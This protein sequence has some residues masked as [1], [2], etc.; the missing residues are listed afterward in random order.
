MIRL[1]SAAMK[2]ENTWVIIRWVLVAVIYAATVGISIDQVKIRDAKVAKLEATQ[3]ETKKALKGIKELAGSMEDTAKSGLQ[4]SKVYE[5]R[6]LT[7]QQLQKQEEAKLLLQK[8]SK[9][10]TELNTSKTSSQMDKARENEKILVNDLNQFA[11]D[12]KALDDRR[13]A[14]KADLDIK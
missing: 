2:L 6:A 12:F 7:L 3:L 10:M 1:D 13:K 5:L 9:I 14:L 4:L 11:A 8:S